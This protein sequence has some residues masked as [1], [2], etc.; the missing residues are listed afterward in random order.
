[1][2]RVGY[3]VLVIM[4]ICIIL[5]YIYLEYSMYTSVYLEYCVYIVLFLHIVKM[6][7]VKLAGIC[8]I[9]YTTLM[10]NLS[11]FNTLIYTDG[12]LL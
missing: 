7:Y 9:I 8:V 5:V 4:Y 6:R 10:Y 3:G 12:R 1:M 11:I 2:S